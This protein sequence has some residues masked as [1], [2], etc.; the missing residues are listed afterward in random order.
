M[1]K[2]L[3]LVATLA[4]AS[5]QVLAAGGHDL[6]PKHG[7]VVQEVRDI[8]YELVA[9]GGKIAVHLDDHGKPVP[10]AGA[11][12][13]ATVLRGTEKSEVDLVPAGDNRLESR[14]PIEAGAG[15]KVVTVVTLPGKPAATARFTLK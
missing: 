6:K 7:G 13:R 11:S 12:G 8:T 15:A 4:A 1:F 10:T 3:I 9:R 5:T 14:T 2:H